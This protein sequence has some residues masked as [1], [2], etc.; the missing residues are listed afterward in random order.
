MTQAAIICLFNEKGGAGKTTTSCQLAGTLG[1]RGYDVL[2]AD[3]D[4]QQTS[5][6]WL[7]QAGGVDFKATLWTGFRY[8]SSVPQEIQK[9]ASKYQIIVAD[10][11][12]SVNNPATWGM[13]L[14]ADLALIPT[15][16]SPPDMHALPTAKRLAKRAIEACGRDYPVRVIANAAHMHMADD[17]DFVDILKSDLEIPPLVTTIGDRKAYSRSMLFGSTAHGVKGSKDAVREI[18]ALADEVLDLIK[19]PR[20]AKGK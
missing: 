16:L 14:V 18:E 6:T 2:V 10:C 9:L 8:G 12:P 3:L 13:L 7:A 20:M 19:F 5:S 11:A 15:K 17:K 1:H 4:E